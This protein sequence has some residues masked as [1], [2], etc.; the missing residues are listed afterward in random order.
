MHAL[1]P[2]FGFCLLFL[3]NV[4]LFNGDNAQRL[5]RAAGR[6]RVERHQYAIARGDAGEVKGLGF[7][8]VGLSGRDALQYRSGWNL[9]RVHLAG[10]RF[11]SQRVAADGRYGAQVVNHLRLSATHG[12]QARNHHRCQDRSP[13]PHRS[14]SHKLLLLNV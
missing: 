6:V 10:V 11:Y 14:Q 12:R 4:C 7:A 1:V 9:N 5:R 3:S 2:L 8:Q 13:A